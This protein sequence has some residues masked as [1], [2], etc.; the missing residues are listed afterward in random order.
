MC[1]IG[2]K[3]YRIWTT[4]WVVPDIRTEVWPTTDRDL[5]ILLRNG[6][7]QGHQGLIVTN[8]QGCRKF[9]IKVRRVSCLKTELIAE[10]NFGFCSESTHLQILMKLGIQVN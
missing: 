9:P 6:A 7:P 4:I 1:I 8:K 10:E 3:L 2:E 5:K